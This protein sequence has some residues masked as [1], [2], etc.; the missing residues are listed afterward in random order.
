M[1]HGQARVAF[2]KPDVRA[3]YPPKAPQEGMPG[4]GDVKTYAGTVDAFGTEVVHLFVPYQV[5]E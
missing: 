1:R 2:E 3:S 4:V 5:E